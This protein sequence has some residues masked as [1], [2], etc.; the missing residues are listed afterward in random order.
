VAFGWA[1]LMALLLATIITLIRFRVPFNCR[2][3][4]KLRIDL[5]L[6]LGAVPVSITGLVTN[7]PRFVRSVYPGYWGRSQSLD[8]SLGFILVTA[9]LSGAW[10]F[11]AAVGLLR[12]PRFW[13]SYSRRIRLTM[14]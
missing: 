7:L 13:R 6:M 2:L 10:I 8:G 1:L 4:G 12:L 14:Q 5:A 9:F 11:L 3:G